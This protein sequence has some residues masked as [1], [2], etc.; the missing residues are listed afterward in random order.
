MAHLITLS[1][2][3]R[4][5]PI[6]VLSDD[7][8]ILFA[9]A[10]AQTAVRAEYGDPGRFVG[11]KV[12]DYAPLG[13]RERMPDHDLYAAAFRPELLVDDEPAD[14]GNLVLTVS[15]H[16]V[17]VIDLPDGSTAKVFLHEI[18]GRGR[19]ML[20]VEAPKMTRVRAR[21]ITEVEA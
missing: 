8:R 7:D 5:E 9:L 17:V 12:V 18:I 6:R 13:D 19:V 3:A 20:R 2:A 11:A 4:P 15:T 16:D 10:E 14:V 1:V 21:K